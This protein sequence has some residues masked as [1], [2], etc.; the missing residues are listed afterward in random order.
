MAILLACSTHTYI[1][2]GFLC[3]RDMGFPVLR[4][5]L[6]SHVNPKIFGES[7]IS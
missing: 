6:A 3:I 4:A 7:V 5:M 1:V 2:G